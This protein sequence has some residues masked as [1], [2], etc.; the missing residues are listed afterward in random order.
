MKLEYKRESKGKERKRGGDR[1]GKR[2]E[3][4]GKKRKEGKGERKK[5][6]EKRKREEKRAKRGNSFFELQSAAPKSKENRIPDWKLGGSVPMRSSTKFSVRS[7]AIGNAR[8]SAEGI[9][10][11]RRAAGG[12]FENFLRPLTL[13]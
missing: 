5:G 6:R 7:P 8:S 9:R 4:R 12:L 1:E 11:P 2:E 13:R 10:W 3:K